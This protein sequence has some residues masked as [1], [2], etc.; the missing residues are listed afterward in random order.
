HRTEN[1]LKTATERRLLKPPSV[2]RYSLVYLFIT[3]KFC[4]EPSSIIKETKYNPE[5]RSDSCS[6]LL[7]LL[8]VLI[9]RP[10]ASV[11]VTDCTSE[12]S[13]TDRTSAKGFGY[14]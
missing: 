2:F 3:L 10:E 13:E 5:E 12:T 9:T 4:T 1:V 6:C 8:T 11:T 7:T 14:T